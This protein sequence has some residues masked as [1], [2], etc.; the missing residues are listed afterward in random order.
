MAKGR[1]PLTAAAVS[2]I[3]KDIKRV[4]K[5][6]N[7]VVQV[8]L[9]SF[10][11]LMIYQSIDNLVR[12]IAYSVLAAISLTAFILELVFEA[13]IDEEETINERKTRKI[14]KRSRKLIYKYIKYASRVTIVVMA[15]VNLIRFGGSDLTIIATIFSAFLIVLNVA[16]DVITSLT[17][18]YVAMIR[19][20]FMTDMEEGGVVKGIVKKF[21][22]NIIDYDEG[23]GELTEPEIKILEQLQKEAK[24]KEDKE[25]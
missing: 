13:Q 3:L 1:F 18:K 15:V 19:I 5:I 8:L 22:K 9:I 7:I 20:G 16:V 6:T 10:Y 25:N 14:N 4:A 17:L 23:L 11:G 2:S 21:T 12:L 24:D